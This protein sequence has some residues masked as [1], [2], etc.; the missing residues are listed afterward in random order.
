MIITPEVEVLQNKGVFLNALLEREKHC[1]LDAQRGIFLS[2]HK[3]KAEKFHPKTWPW[4][5]LK[6]IH[7]SSSQSQK[8][9]FSQLL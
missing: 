7:Q 3:I 5:S 6:A 2:F 1:L 8:R 4:K 9:D